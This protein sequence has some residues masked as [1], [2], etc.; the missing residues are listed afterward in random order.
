MK[1]Q[2]FDML[3]CLAFAYITGFALYALSTHGDVPV[4][5]IG[6]LAIIGVVGLVVDLIIVFVY[7]VRKRPA[8]SSLR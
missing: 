8:N 5:S 3:G 4:W 7:F 6:L 1:P 2:H